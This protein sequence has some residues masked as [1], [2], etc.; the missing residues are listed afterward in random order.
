MKRLPVPFLL[1]RQRWAEIQNQHLARH[2]HAARGLGRRPERHLGASRVQNL[3]PHEVVALLARRAAEGELERACQQ[4]RLLDLSG[5]LATVQAARTERQRLERLS[6]RELAQELARLRPRP[7]RELVEEDPAVLHAAQEARTFEA[8]VPAA[9]AAH[10][11]QRWREDH[12]LRAH[13]HDAGAFRSAYLVERARVQDEARHE[14][15]RV[16]PRLAAAEQ[17]GQLARRAAAVRLTDEYRPIQE[18]LAELAQLQEVTA[19]QERAAEVQR[20]AELTRTQ[21]PETFRLLAQKRQMGMHGFHDQSPQWQATPPA[22]RQ[23]LD[24][25]NR[26]SA[27]VQAAMLARLR[28]DPQV[29]AQVADLLQQRGRALGRGRSR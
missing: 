7:V 13:A 4:V 9:Q 10:E 22:L 21:A 28:D 5:D 8:Q 20:R 24:Q 18:Q 29:R 1:S 6:S 14:Q 2:G 15:N 25:F 11:A 12:P 26:Q 16:A 23:L 19:R 27:A 17:R 3:S